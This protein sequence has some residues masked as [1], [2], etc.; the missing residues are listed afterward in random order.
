M[1]V[2]RI[3]FPFSAA[4]DLVTRARH[5]V[6][7]ARGRA[8]ASGPVRWEGQGTRESVSARMTDWA[9]PSGFVLVPPRIEKADSGAE[10]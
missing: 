9:R 3:R 8:A 4:L 7:P 1:P 6:K 10:E 2:M 5:A